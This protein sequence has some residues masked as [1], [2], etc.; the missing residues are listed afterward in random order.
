MNHVGVINPTGSFL[1]HRYHIF[2]MKQ[3]LQRL[4]QLASERLR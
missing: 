2:G 1:L 3:R 4:P